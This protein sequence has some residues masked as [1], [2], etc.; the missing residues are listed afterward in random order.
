M[1]E[2]QRERPFREI[3]RG[4]EQ[5]LR[6]FG[7]TRCI[8]CRTIYFKKKPTAIMTVNRRRF[9]FLFSSSSF[10]FLSFFFAHLFLVPLLKQISS[11]H[12]W[13]QGLSEEASPLPT[14]LISANYDSLGAAGL[15]ATGDNDNG[16][17]VAAVLELARLFST[18][19]HQPRNRVAIN[20]LF[21]ITGGSHFN[22]LGTEAWLAQMDKAL[23]DRIDFAICLDSIG[24]SE[25]LYLHHSRPP[26]TPKIKAVYDLFV[27]QAQQYG[28]DIEL[29][30]KK[31]NISSET[32]AWE[33]E[34]FARKS[35]FSM[36][37]SGHAPAS[38]VAKWSA[39]G[40]RS[41]S[42]EH[43]SGVNTTL[44]SRNIAFVAEV[45][46]KHAFGFN[47]RKFNVFEGS[48]A[49]DQASVEAWVKIL[50]AQ[51]RV[52][53]WIEKEKPHPALNLIHERLQVYTEKVV[54][55]QYGV[56]SGMQF[57][58]PVSST[59]SAYFV[60][61]VVFELLLSAGVVLYLLVVAGSLEWY[62]TGKINWKSY[63]KRD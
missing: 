11:F 45:L 22:F 9:F 59:M 21:L 50:S 41:S 4:L 46:A 36:T 60:R 27:E 28:V 53:P 26:K 40:K 51:H 35:I 44:L 63:L 56:P 52:D 3:E 18:L 30:R 39:N 16:S 38:P 6:P 8:S 19:Y 37:L 49:V 7:H 13:L 55:R 43:H 1:Y 33:H 57:R 14:I 32:I 20:F 17:G 42:L 58:A 23:L 2:W 61:G 47:G 48:L 15:F 5:K 34:S 10:L 62:T 25:R 31:V 24:N 29:S 12:G 54:V